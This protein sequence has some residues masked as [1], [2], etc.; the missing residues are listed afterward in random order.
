MVKRSEIGLGL[1]AT[2]E[3]PKETKIIEYTGETIRNDDTARYT[4]RYLFKIDDEYTIDGKSRGNTAR[5]INHSCR[6]NAYTEIID[7]KIWVIAKRKIKTGEEITYHYG[8]EYFNHFIKPIGC[9]CA[10]CNS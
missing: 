6:P 4:G 7:G 1:F 8:K 9:K 10:K 3:I 5:Y 2:A